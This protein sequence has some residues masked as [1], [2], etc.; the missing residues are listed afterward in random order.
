MRLPIVI[1][2]CRGTLSIISYAIVAHLLVIVSHA[3]PIACVRHAWWA[4]LNHQEA[5]TV[6][7]LSL[8]VRPALPIMFVA[9]AILTMWLTLVPVST[10]HPQLVQIV[11]P[12]VYAQFV[13]L[14]ILSPMAVAIRAQSQTVRP[15]QPMGIVAHVLVPTLQT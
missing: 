7:Q 5:A 12:A 15:V 14:A 9:H 4:T 13:L 8:T 10:V 11:L 6:A 2:V 1:A 3:V